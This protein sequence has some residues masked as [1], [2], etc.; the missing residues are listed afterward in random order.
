MQQTNMHQQSLEYKKIKERDK[1]KASVERKFHYFVVLYRRV[2]FRKR[3]INSPEAQIFSLSCIFH[4]SSAAFFKLF[5]FSTQLNPPLTIKHTTTTAQHYVLCSA[6][7]DFSCIPSLNHNKN[8]KKQP[9]NDD[10][11]S[12]YC[13]TEPKRCSDAGKIKSVGKIYFAEFLFR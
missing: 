6:K 13:T 3:H 7:R 5:L 4:H 2:V 1:I 9:L 8:Q 12:F 11:R 10:N